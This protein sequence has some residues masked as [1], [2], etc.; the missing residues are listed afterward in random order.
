MPQKGVPPWRAAE[1]PD[2]LL[3]ED[4]NAFHVGGASSSDEDSDSGTQ[5]FECEVQAR[6]SPPIPGKTSRGV[7][8]VKTQAADLAE[9]RLPQRV[10]RLTASDVVRF[11]LTPPHAQI[12]RGR[13]GS[14]TFAT[15]AALAKHRASKEHRAVVNAALLT[16][17]GGCVRLPASCVHSCS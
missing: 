7:V 11:Y 6:S 16:H 5:V 1:R 15:A 9:P 8:S 17:A 3:D 13:E 10:P 12:C 2:A 4:R 14:C